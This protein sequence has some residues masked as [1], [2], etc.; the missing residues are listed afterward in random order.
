MDRDR[1]LSFLFFFFFFFSF[2][3]FTGS[4]DV[5]FF[6]YLR[7]CFGELLSSSSFSDSDFAFSSSRSF[8]FSFL[9]LSFLLLICFMVLKSP[10]DP[11]EC[12][13]V[14]SFLGGGGGAS[15]S[16][17]L[18][19]GEY[20]SL[21]LDGSGVGDFSFSGDLAGEG[22]LELDLLSLFLVGCSGDFSE[23]ELDSRDLDCFFGGGDADFPLALL[24]LTDLLFDFFFGDSFFGSGDLDAEPERSESE[25]DLSSFFLGET[26]FSGVSSFFAKF[27][28]FT[29][30][31]ELSEE[32][33][34][35]FLALLVFFFLFLLPSDEDPS[36]DEVESLRAFFFLPRDLSSEE[37]VEC[38]LLLRSL[39]VS[40]RNLGD[41]EAFHW[42]RAT[43]IVYRC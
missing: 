39:S 35:L 28:R 36:D 8:L 4:G 12:S 3:C 24:A 33:E 21:S 9:P 2:L 5:D 25:P 6:L 15:A 42:E 18:F 27:F 38:R 1:C 34:C 26:A 20:L 10:S 23:A 22:D 7:S 14:C 17:S 40:S 30:D 37:D 16:E 29:G 32:E 31:A 41:F 11:S 13:G 43:A 19:P